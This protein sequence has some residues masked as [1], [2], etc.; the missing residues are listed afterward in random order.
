MRYWVRS[1]GLQKKKRKEGKKMRNF[2]EENEN[3]ETIEFYE[4]DQRNDGE[5][6]QLLWD[7]IYCYA[8]QYKHDELKEEF[9]NW[10][11]EDAEAYEEFAFDELESELEVILNDQGLIL[12]I[13]DSTLF[14]EQEIEKPY[15][16]YSST[17]DD[18]SCLEKSWFMIDIQPAF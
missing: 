10:E 4:L 11:N 9:N 7:L 16:K 13:E 6:F 18:I 1:H 17:I 12:R 8:G 3:M 15:R 2:E 14:I 5:S